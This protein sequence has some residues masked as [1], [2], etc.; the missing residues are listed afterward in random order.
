MGGLFGA[1]SDAA[2]AAL[3]VGGA[4]VDAVHDFFNKGKG[5]I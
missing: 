2:G 1:A 5:K 4:G 3:D